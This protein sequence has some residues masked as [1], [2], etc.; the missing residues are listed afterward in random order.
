MKKFAKISLLLLLVLTMALCFVACGEEPDNGGSTPG[1]GSSGG[2]GG[3]DDSSLQTIYTNNVTF[4]DKVVAYDGRLKTHETYKGKPEPEADERYEYWLN[5]EKVAD[6]EGVS[7]VGIYE[8]RL[9]FSRK[10]YKETYVTSTLT[11]EQSYAV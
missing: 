8:V 9:Y 4:N 7:E 5:G 3:G 11:I 6:E 10:G 2:G 1:G